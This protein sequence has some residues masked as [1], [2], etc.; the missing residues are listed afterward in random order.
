M[1]DYTNWI[2]TTSPTSRNDGAEICSGLTWIA[3]AATPSRND[4]L[5]GLATVWIATTVL[6]PRND[7][8]EYTFWKFVI[9]SPQDEAYCCERS[10]AESS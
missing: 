7:G 6:P 8:K 1:D 9:A 3:T 2:A 10:A 4:V 5:V